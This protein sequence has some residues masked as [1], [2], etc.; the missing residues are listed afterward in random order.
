MACYSVTAIL[1]LGTAMAGFQAS[2]QLACWIPVLR[3]SFNCVTAQVIT[4]AHILSLQAEMESTQKDTFARLSQSSSELASWALDIYHFADADIPRFIEELPK[5]NF[6]GKDVI[7]EALF[8]SQS[9]AIAAKEHLFNF[10]ISMEDSAAMTMWTSKVI[11]CRLEVQRQFSGSSELTQVEIIQSSL[12]SLDTV[13]D[14]MHYACDASICTA[15]RLVLTLNG[16]FKLIDNELNLDRVEK[17]KLKAHVWT[18]LG[19]NRLRLQTLDG[20]I[21]Y[22]EVVLAFEKPMLRGL[23]NLK[24]ILSYG[25]KRIRLIKSK[26]KMEKNCDTEIEFGAV[27][28]LIGRQHNPIILT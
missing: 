3:N 22:F 28:V 13:I 23:R 9:D 8:D 19:G 5:F 11:D 4:S 2:K 25:S 18:M 14:H 10:F 6:T 12:Q 7:V 17:E 1:P 27:E 15:N 26:L 16:L 21:T 24:Y 20:K